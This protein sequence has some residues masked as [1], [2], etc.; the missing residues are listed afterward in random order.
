MKK[1]NLLIT[2]IGALLY[3]SLSFGVSPIGTYPDQPVSFFLL[4]QLIYPLVL[5]WSLTV[6]EILVLNKFSIRWVLKILLTGLFIFAIFYVANKLLSLSTHESEVPFICNPILACILFVIFKIEK[7]SW[8][9]VILSLIIGCFIIVVTLGVFA[10]FQQSGSH[11]A[12]LFIFIFTVLGIILGIV[13]GLLK[14]MIVFLK[15][16]YETPKLKSKDE[17]T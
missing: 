1:G 10:H 16:K 7:Y 6:S 15:T 12:E 8:L 11:G 9:Y 14:D 3:I 13:A 17:T 5:F 2:F 4:H